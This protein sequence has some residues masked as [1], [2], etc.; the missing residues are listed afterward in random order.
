MYPKFVTQWTAVCQTPLYFTISR[1]LLKF[2]FIESVMEYNNLILWCPLLLLPSFFRSI[3]VF[4][5]ESALPIRWPKFWSF[6]LSIS[7]SNEY[8]G[9][10]T[11]RTDWFDLFADQG[12]LKSLLQH[13]SLKAHIFWHS[14]FLMAQ[15]PIHM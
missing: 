8:S 10:I 9:L 15:L 3:K 11:F 12:T 7:L 5:N 6:S 13:H 4:S 1:G 14:G 2:M